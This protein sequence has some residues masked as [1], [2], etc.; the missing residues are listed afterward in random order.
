MPFYWPTHHTPEFTII[1]S[2]YPL[3]PAILI[4][5]LIAIVHKLVEH[6]LFDTAT[7]ITQRTLTLSKPSWLCHPETNP[8][9]PTTKC[10]IPSLAELRRI[11][12]HI[13]SLNDESEFDILRRY[14][15]S[16]GLRQRQL[17]EL[18]SWFLGV[19]SFGV[20]R[21]KFLE[22]A[23][24]LIVI[25]PISVFGGYVVYFEHDFFVHHW[26]QWLFEGQSVAIMDPT[27]CSLD[28][29]NEPLVQQY[30]DWMV[31]YYVVSLGYHLNR[32][33]AQFSNPSRKDFVAMFIHHWATLILMTFSF[34]SGSIRYPAS[35]I[36]HILF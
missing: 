20:Q 8:L 34:V 30:D 32:A 11:E 10:T 21:D 13:E 23:F 3:W 17:R 9:S 31:L 26:K 22:S 4:C 33:L 18:K 35:K 19:K 5:L 29:A 27:G 15:S 12:Q 7:R 25:V 36:K 2:P 16:I 24:K 1:T 6:F 14:G 28:G